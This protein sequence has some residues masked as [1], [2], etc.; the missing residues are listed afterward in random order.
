MNETELIF[1]CLFLFGMGYAAGWLTKDFRRIAERFGIL[2]FL[3]I[4]VPIVT[5]VLA[6]TDM[7][8]HYNNLTMSLAFAGG[9]AYRMIKRA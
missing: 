7:I 3:F 1:Y 2:L 6:T 5:M 8:I 4:L 9:F